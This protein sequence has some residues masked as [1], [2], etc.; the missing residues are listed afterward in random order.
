MLGTR[1]LGTTPFSLPVSPGEYRLHFFLDGYR[2]REV[3]VFVSPDAEEK[4]HGALTP[5]PDSWE[6]EL[7]PTGSV[8]E[9]ADFNDETAFARP[10]AAI[11][12]T[13]TTYPSPGLALS[14]AISVPLVMSGVGA[15]IAWKG[16]EA[17]ASVGGIL[18]VSGVLLGPSAGHIYAGRWGPAGAHIGIR[19]VL[20]FATAG[21]IVA[22]G[23]LRSESMV[24]AL[25][26]GGALLVGDILFEVA[27]TW[28]MAR[29]AR[30][31]RIASFGS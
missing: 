20:L 8:V 2:H 12:R 16:S 22:G 18:A 27:T 11:A 19:V 23:G 25:A 3:V 17:F 31:A 28:V 15:L 7:R 5:V 1:N 30:R 6:A 13:T 29:R 9:P 26:A 14:L 10:G 24:P 4:A 21:G